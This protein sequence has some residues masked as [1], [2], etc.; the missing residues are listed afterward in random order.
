MRKP[1]SSWRDTLT[2]LGFKARRG[3]KGRNQPKPRSLQMESL[4]S[5]QLLTTNLAITGFSGDG[6]DLVVDYDILDSNA[7]AFDIGIYRSADGVTA[8]PDTLL[9]T[10]RISDSGD[11]ELGSRSVSITA[12]FSSAAE[13]YFLVAV[14]DDSLEV[15]ETDEFDNEQAFDGG[16]FCAVDGTV[17]V[18]GPDGDD[19]D[20]ITLSLSTTVD[21][22][23]NGVTH[24][25]TTGDVAALQVRTHGGNDKITS[26]LSGSKDLTFF[27]GDQ[28]D[29]RDMARL[30]GLADYYDEFVAHPT[31]ATMTTTLGTATTTIEV[32]G[33]EDTRAWAYSGAG[34]TDLAKLYGADGQ[35][36]QLTSRPEDGYTLL[37]SGDDP[38]VDFY[39]R[40]EGFS[41][42]WGIGNE[43]D[44][45]LALMYGTSGDDNVTCKLYEE[46]ATFTMLAG[47]ND[48][49]T[50]AKEF[51]EFSVHGSG[52]FDT[53]LLFGGDSWADPGIS[54]DDT[55]TVTPRYAYSW[56]TMDATIETSLTDTTAFVRGFEEVHGYV[57]G[58]KGRGDDHATVFGTEE[59]DEMELDLD[60]IT[61]TLH[62]PQNRLVELH[63]FDD[64]H[65]DA[66]AENSGYDRIYV[67]LCD[68]D[69]T[70]DQVSGE[71]AVSFS[72]GVDIT[73][74]L[75][76]F[77]YAE[78]N[79]DGT[80][81]EV[82]LALDA[83]DDQPGDED[84]PVPDV[85][86]PVVQGGPDRRGGLHAAIRLQRPRQLHI[87]GDRR[88]PRRGAGRVD[89]PRG[90]GPDYRHPGQRPA[91]SRRPK[92]HDRRRYWRR[93]HAH[94]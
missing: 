32:Y 41:I 73:D 64:A 15:A 54:G 10:E 76:G 91:D 45:D 57:K 51:K 33:A 55:L 29:G 58:V 20:T 65:V 24:S 71:H 14:L 85:A 6:A 92:R 22:T 40:A 2:R 1:I 66:T 13:D 70:L 21:V 36:D 30:H 16:T 90:H 81:S 56:L 72:N 3:R 79:P 59:D 89:Q 80:G 53:A 28:T 68:G 42:V 26:R 5:R 84:M 8:T 75:S 86:V 78:G 27:G 19:A 4:E 67:D 38:Q 46:R 37:K 31:Y 12:D 43:D 49:R 60:Y 77:E 74:K 17:H 35:A 63:G 34:D 11:L 52:G 7:T 25:F 62:M 48:F 61:R 69:Y 9:L 94:R 23:L 18:H 50:N 87:H 88:R 83:I 82:R 44:D 47:T 39:L 93:D